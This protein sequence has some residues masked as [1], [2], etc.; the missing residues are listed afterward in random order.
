MHKFLRDIIARLRRCVQGG[1]RDTTGPAFGDTANPIRDQIDHEIDLGRFNTA[2]LTRV[3]ILFGGIQFHSQAI[4]DMLLNELSRFDTKS[5]ARV[6]VFIKWDPFDASA[7]SVWNRAGRPHPRWV[8]IPIADAVV[9]RRLSFTHHAAVRE[10]A[11]AHDLACSTEEER[12]EARERLRQHWKKLA[13]RPPV[14]ENRQAPR[15]VDP[16][17][18]PLHSDVRFTFD[19]PLAWIEEAPF[20]ADERSPRG[21][22][23]SKA[24][25]AKTKRTKKRKKAETAATPTPRLPD[26]ERK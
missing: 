14:R 2:V 4:T 24:A 22:K 8:T 13:D 15:D 26:T 6:K 17:D 1:L 16:W 21:R 11:K 19:D 18:G 20:V 9:G 7:I 5:N 25:I 12:S 3:G 10:F 23:P